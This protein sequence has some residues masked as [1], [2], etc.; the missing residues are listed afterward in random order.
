MG[1]MMGTAGTM[2]AWVLLWVLLAL[3][4]GVTSGIVIAR[5]RHSRR[6]AAAPPVSSADSPAVRKAKDALR[7]RYAHGEISREDYLQGKVELED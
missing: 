4:V 5:G 1:A 2:G 3:A 7:L 6:D